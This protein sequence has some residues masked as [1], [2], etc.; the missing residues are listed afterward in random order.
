MFV[1]N[2]SAITSFQIGR[3]KSETDIIDSI[4]LNTDILSQIDSA[5]AFI[6]KN[7]MVSYIITGNAQR[8]ER[9]DYPLE[10]IREIVVNM[11]V[12]RDYRDS[13]HSIIKIYDDR[14][15]FFN[16]GKLYDDLT[17][18]KLQTGNYA[19]R[20]RNR[21]IASILKECGMI[22]RYGSGIKR[23]NLACAQ[24]GLANPVFE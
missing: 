13:G 15:E 8:E 12:H 14:I 18:E 10:A 20:T 5:I 23:I 17:I 2:A 9:Y 19:S 22:E 1:D 21:A 6:R 11:V 7:L 16:P 3:F 24:Y 4:D